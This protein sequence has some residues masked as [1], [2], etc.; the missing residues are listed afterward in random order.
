MSI[1]EEQLRLGS[2]PETEVV[3]DARHC[4]KTTLTRVKGLSA[5]VMAKLSAKKR[6][7]FAHY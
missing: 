2:N 5:N 1:S 7:I 4:N 3:R 6:G